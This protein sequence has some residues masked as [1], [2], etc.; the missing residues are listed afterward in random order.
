MLKY[1]RATLWKFLVDLKSAGHVIS[2]IF[3]SFSCIYPIFSIF[4]KNGYLFANIILSLFATSYLVFYIVTY[5]KN[6]KD[7]KDKKDTARAVYKWCKRGISLL[8][9]CIT[10]Y[11][12]YFA[13]KDTDFFTLLYPVFMVVMWVVD[14]VFAIATI[15]L[16]SRID[17]LCSAFAMDVE[18]VKR[19]GNFFK[20]V[21]GDEID[22][23]PVAPKTRTALEKIAQKH[24]EVREEK[25]EQRQVDKKERNRKRREVWAGRIR[26]AFTGKKTAENTTEKDVPTQSTAKK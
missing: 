1:T 11:S 12:V 8:T 20:T 16:E 21:V 18:G 15:Y 26:S 2:L 19:V 3:Y 13:S 14:L 22:D 10:V 24:G 17:L 25:R 6:T 9:L 4:M 7:D 5:N 23:D